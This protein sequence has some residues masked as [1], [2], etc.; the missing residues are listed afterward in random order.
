MPKGFTLAELLIALAILGVIATF[1][2]PKIL[3]AQA[4]GRYNATAK[5]AIAMVAAAYQQAQFAGGVSGTTTAGDLT[6]YMNYV[7]TDTSTLIDDWQ[8]GTTWGCNNTE[9]CLVLHNGAR[10]V[11][12][13]KTFTQRVGSTAKDNA[14]VFQFDPDGVYSG[15]TNGPGKSLAIVLYYD[16]GIGTQGTARPA[17]FYPTT[18]PG[19][20]FDPPWFSW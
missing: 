13:D 17:S 4:N 15:T 16:G 19:A 14:L 18:Y 5:E 7:A 3:T 6:P 1:S 10:L 9:R 2:I 8:T 12:D 11:Y 20:N